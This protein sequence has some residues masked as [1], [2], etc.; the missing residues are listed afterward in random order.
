M[1]QDLNLFV[2][3]I[4]S[5]VIVPKRM[6]LEDTGMDLHAHSFKVIYEHF[7]SNGERKVSDKIIEDLN[8]DRFIELSYMERVLIGTGLKVT[9]GTPGYDIQIRPRSGLALKQGITVCNTPGTID[10]N[11][12]DELCV[13]LINLS[14]A[15][16]QI[17]LGDRI[18]QLVVAPVELPKVEVVPH[19]PTTEDRGGGFGSTGA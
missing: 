6:T 19:L 7:G 13:I 15:N 12:K 9:V 14:R 1:N 16:Q 4:Y 18:A 2:E 10:L 8:K 3:K 17:S 5:D 11:Y